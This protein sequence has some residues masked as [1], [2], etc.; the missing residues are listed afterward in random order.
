MTLSEALSVFGDYWSFLPN[1]TITMF[2]RPM[3]AWKMHHQVKKITALLSGYF[4]M[5]ELCLICCGKHPNPNFLI[6]IQDWQ[7]MAMLKEKMR[8]IK[9]TMPGMG[10]SRSAS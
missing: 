10:L 6:T 3:R 5:F 1:I 2:E 4:D 7:Y 9:H 8:E